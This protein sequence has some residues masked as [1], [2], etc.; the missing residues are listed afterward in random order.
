ML[1]R[2]KLCISKHEKHNILFQ[3]NITI[4]IIT[5]AINLWTSIYIPISEMQ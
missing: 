5:V 1:H 2:D 4:W 3:Y